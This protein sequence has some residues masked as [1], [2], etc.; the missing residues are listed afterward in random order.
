MKKIFTAMMALALATVVIFTGCA[1][2]K[3]PEEIEQERLESIAQE[4][5]STG[6]KR[7]DSPNFT[8]YE[9]PL[10]QLMQ[11]IKE[12]DAEK[13][14]EAVGSPWVLADEDIYGWALQNGLDYVQQEE[15]AN[16]KIRSE[17]E[18]ATATITLY[19]PTEDPQNKDAGQV[20][21][22]VYEN[23]KWILIP[24]SG[25]EENYTFTAPSRDVSCGEVSLK[26]YAI[27][28]DNNGTWTFKIPHM[29][30]AN[31]MENFKVSTQL[32]EFNAIMINPSAG[33]LVSSTSELI[34]DMTEEQRAEYTAVAQTAFQKVFDLLK[35]GADKNQ[36]SEVLVSE[37][38]ISGCFPQAEEEKANLTANLATVTGVEVYPGNPSNQ[39][40]DAYVYRVYKDNGIQMDVKLKVLTTAGE[41]RKIA[42]VTMQ[43][44]NNEW[45]IA[46]VECKNQQNPF[47]DFSVFDPEW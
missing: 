43:Y 7:L 23:G 25:V 21:T 42:T 39:Y 20:F 19:K 15:L 32:G 26:D 28:V 11:G 17:K 35:S 36:L 29:I 10:Q 45:K 8:D 46:S 4:E 27:A 16:L 47:T 1:A 12:N 31:S 2:E 18:N 24:E 40:P 22:S 30:V 9:L 41:S 33:S 14:C 38:L 6:L 5:E 3:T 44:L 13:I 34:A 37:Q